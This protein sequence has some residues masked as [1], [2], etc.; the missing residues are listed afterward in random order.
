VVTAALDAEVDVLAGGGLRG[1]IRFVPDLDAAGAVA[2]RAAD[3]ALWLVERDALSDVRRQPTVDRT[4][5]LWSARL[6]GA[7]GRI[8]ETTASALRDRAAVALAADCVGGAA[9]CLDAT[10]EYLRSRRQF[11][12][13][14]GSFQALQHRCA[15]M[16]LALERARAATAHAAEHPA[17]PAAVSIAKSLAGDAYVLIAEEAVSMH[18]GVG[19]TWEQGTHRFL[20]RARLNEAWMG[21]GRWHRRRLARLALEGEA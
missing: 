9:A 10:V 2:V 13:P 5:S 16:L 4:R 1:A 3:D 20:K 21:D 19:F 6:D 12:R 11:G 17:S 14:I 7:A 15:D 8:L 18:G